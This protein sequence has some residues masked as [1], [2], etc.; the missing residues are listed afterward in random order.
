MNQPPQSPDSQAQQSVKEEKA[1]Q[2]EDT[3]RWAG[4]SDRGIEKLRNGEDRTGP[5][6]QRL[7]KAVQ[8]KYPTMGRES[9]EADAVRPAVL[10]SLRFAYK[11]GSSLQELAYRYEYYKA[12]YDEQRKDVFDNRND[13]SNTEKYALTHRRLATTDVQGILDA[14]TEIIQSER[15]NKKVEIDLE[16]SDEDVVASIRSQAEEI[17]MGHDT[18]TAYHARKHFLELPKEEQKGHPVAAYLKSLATTIREGEVS[19]FDRLDE[20]RAAG[21]TMDRP[22]ARNKNGPPKKPDARNRESKD[23]RPE[24][25]ILRARIFVRPQTGAVAPTHMRQ[26]SDRSND[27]ERG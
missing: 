17:G 2:L 7:A 10:E 26:K 5:G 11:G 20:G 12:L 1:T 4:M 16:A 21:L 13:L 24:T 19:S 18:S 25:S 14:D 23:D 15:T 22:L 6:W 27:H 8:N 9:K 3:L